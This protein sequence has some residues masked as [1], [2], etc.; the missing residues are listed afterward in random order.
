MDNLLLKKSL[1]G[2]SKTS[3]CEY[4]AKQNDDFSKRLM[5][6][7]EDADA[8]K[9]ALQA[10]VAMLEQE[11]SKLRA[12]H[13]NITQVLLDAQ[14]HANDLRRKADEENRSFRAANKDLYES[15]LQRLNEYRRGIEGIR[16]ALRTLIED[17]DREMAKHEEIVNLALAQ[18]VFAE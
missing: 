11:N 7:M 3:V 5:T 15:Q 9:Q 6:V 14:H 17:C 2:Y 1:F 10:R 18:E 8:Q 4:I 16:N 12:D 13:D